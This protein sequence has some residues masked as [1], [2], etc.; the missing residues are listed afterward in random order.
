M[1][2]VLASP[3]HL[4]LNV[5]A[6]PSPALVVIWRLLSM[7]FVTPVDVFVLLWGL[8]LSLHYLECTYSMAQCYINIT[9]S[10]KIDHL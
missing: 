8:N 1:F 2:N 6:P 4:I 7:L 5:L 3:S 9:G 10:V